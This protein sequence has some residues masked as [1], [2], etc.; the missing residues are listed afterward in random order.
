MTDDGAIRDLLERQYPT[1]LNG[2]DV[3]AY[4][5]LYDD[6]VVWGVPNLPD[7][8][9]REQIGSLLGKILSKVSQT[10]EVVVDDLVVDGDHA[11][12]MA[13]ATGTAARL[14]DGEPQPL[15]LRVMWGLRR[16]DGEW[17]IIRQVGTPKPTG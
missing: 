12:A 11:I 14:P 6:D 2:A 9:S 7:A 8:R 17:K 5:G 15:A 1:R 3:D 16:V 13:V 10:V 4:V